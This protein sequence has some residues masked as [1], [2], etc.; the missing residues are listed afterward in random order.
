MRIRW[1]DFEI[2]NSV[3]CE[4]ES[5]TPRY[6]KFLIEPFE[7]GFG[8]T[9][10][11]SLRR[12]LL[13]SLEG[14][15]V[16]SVKIEGVQHEFS[17]LT[18]VYED[19]TDIILN[20]KNLLLVLHEGDE[21]TLRLRKDKKGEI[22]GSDIDHD[23]NVEVVN[24]ELHIATLTQ[25]IPFNM[26]LRARRGRGYVNAEENS[27]GDNEIGIIW[28]DSSFSPV[29][30][31]RYKTEDTRVGQVTNYDRLILEIWT[32]GTTFPEMAL[33]EAAKILRKHLNP[34]IQFAD[35]G[36][37]LQKDSGM[38]QEEAENAGNAEE[39][40]RKLNLPISSLS[41]SMRARNCLEGENIKTVGDLVSKS[42]AEMIKVRNFG[43]TSLVEIKK[44]LG[45]MGLSLGMDLTRIQNGKGKIE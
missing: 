27:R 43:K 15:A 9:V 23:A 7:R 2:P 20:I 4:E 12:I 10:G 14:A 22:F 6:G 32:N 40:R 30:R 16:A 1:R 31:V 41:L 26:E 25:D 5:H 8:V 13:S 35:L 28:V 17:T 19:V 38:P 37:Q 42:V 44:K 21:S 29:S 24:P 18:G 3:T 11:N 39:I 33:V 36:Y 34:F 45:E